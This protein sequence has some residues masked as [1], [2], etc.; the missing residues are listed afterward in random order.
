MLKKKTSDASYHREAC[1]WTQLDKESWKKQSYKGQS[2][3]ALDVLSMFI[4]L[5]ELLVIPW[6][7][8]CLMK[9]CALAASS[10][11]RWFLFE[12]C[13]WVRE[14]FPRTVRKSSVMDC[15]A[16]RVCSVTLQNRLFLASRSGALCP[17]SAHSGG[18]SDNSGKGHQRGCVR[19]EAD[20]KSVV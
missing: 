10:H 20:R 3:L 17:G 14:S 15:C 4:C 5:A 18:S 6:L 2:L 12:I 1:C 16:G 13:E 11:W 7:T 8:S 9:T 19:L